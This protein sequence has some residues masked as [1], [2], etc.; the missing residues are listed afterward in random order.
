[1]RGEK[2]QFPAESEGDR[3]VRALRA[4]QERDAV[5]ETSVTR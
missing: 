5:V 1:M 4:G 2:L 3:A